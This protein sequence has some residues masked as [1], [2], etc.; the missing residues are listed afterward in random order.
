MAATT[1]V[2]SDVPLRDM[3]KTSTAERA[4]GTE[5]LAPSRATG[6]S[7]GSSRATGGGVGL[8]PNQDIMRR[9]LRRA[10]VGKLN[11]SRTADL[12]WP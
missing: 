10:A 7:V 1:D 11:R 5:Q 9:L 12:P 6:G 2:E 3:P 4:V 8:L